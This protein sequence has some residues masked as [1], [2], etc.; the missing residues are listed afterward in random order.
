[1]S[2]MLACYTIYIPVQ[3]GEG[4]LPRL[5]H[6]TLISRPRPLLGNILPRLYLVVYRLFF[7]ILALNLRIDQSY[8]IEKSTFSEQALVASN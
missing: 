3:T 1:M 5:F 6:E 4:V 2:S 8:N 7:G